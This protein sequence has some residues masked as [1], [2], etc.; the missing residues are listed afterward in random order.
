MYRIAIA[1]SNGEAVDMHFWQAKS[2]LIYEI[3]DEGVS[4]VEDR[5]IEDVKNEDEHSMK[6]MEIRVEILSDCK[7]VFFLKIGMRSSRYLYEHG[8]KSFEVSYTLNHIFNTLI[9]NKKQGRIKIL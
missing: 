2:F 1:S 8:I 4:F 9:K 6:N 3:G 5:A 7:A